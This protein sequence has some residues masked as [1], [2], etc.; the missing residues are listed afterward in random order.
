MTRGINSPLI[1]PTHNFTNDTGDALWGGLKVD[2]KHSTYDPA[3]LA[4]QKYA[5]NA[6]VDIYALVTGNT[7]FKYQ[8]AILKED[9]I[10]KDNFGNGPRGF[11]DAYC[12]NSTQLNYFWWDKQELKT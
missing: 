7:T 5:I 12:M 11:E 4:V 1:D 10:K 8:G 3:T 6:D 2:I 9:L